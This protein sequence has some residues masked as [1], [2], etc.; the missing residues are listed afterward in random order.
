MAKLIAVDGTVTQVEVPTED[1]ARLKF[2]Q[3]AV[4]GYIQ[5]A[6]KSHEGKMLLVDEDGKLKGKEF[7]ALATQLA[8]SF[9]GLSRADYLVG[10]VL[11]VEYG[12]EID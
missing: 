5:V 2:F 9:H 12:T 3:D 6:G 10:D 8:H 7:N 1:S 11:V 4:G